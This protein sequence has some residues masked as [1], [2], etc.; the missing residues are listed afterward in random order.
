MQPLEKNLRKLNETMPR[1]VDDG[2]APPFATARGTTKDRQ[3][4]REKDKN[5]YV[6]EIRCIWSLQ[7]R[8]EAF[9]SFLFRRKS[10]ETP[11]KHNIA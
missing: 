10:E 11:L 8:G 5:I 7:R 3:R 1:V 6:T 4:K 9:D 2:R